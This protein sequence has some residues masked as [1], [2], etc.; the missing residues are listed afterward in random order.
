MFRSSARPFRA[1]E[2]VKLSNMAVT[3][4]EIIEE[5]RPKTVD[6]RFAAPLE[7]PE[8]LWMRGTRS[9]L[10]TWTPPRVGETVVV[11]AAE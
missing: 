10:A 9:G 8:W 1:G 5:G 6:F 4:I 7:S 11:S 3:V 2:V